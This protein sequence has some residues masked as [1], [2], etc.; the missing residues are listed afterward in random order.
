MGGKRRFGGPFEELGNFDES[1][2]SGRSAC[3]GR[4]VP[5]GGLHDLLYVLGTLSEVF[6]SGYL[7]ERYFAE[8]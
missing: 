2:F 6:I 8:E 1:I 4:D 5:F 7:G 3:E